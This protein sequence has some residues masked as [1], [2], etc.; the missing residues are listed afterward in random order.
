MPETITATTTNVTCV[1]QRTRT[2]FAGRALIVVAGPA[3]WIW[4]TCSLRNSRSVDSFKRAL[5]TFLF[6]AN[7]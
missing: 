4:L 3:A 2:E 7:I 1:V 5:G 6:T